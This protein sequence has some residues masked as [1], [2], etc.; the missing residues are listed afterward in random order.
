VKTGQVISGSQEELSAAR[1][2]RK[3]RLIFIGLLATLIAILSVGGNRSLIKIYQMTKAKGEL[4][5]E[6]ARVKQVNEQLHRDVQSFT[7]DPERVEAMAREELGLVKPGEVVYQF[8][9]P[10]LSPTPSPSP[11]K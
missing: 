1:A 2:A 3:R 9:R 7:N 4:R 8:A 10:R 5:R 6:I 11:Q